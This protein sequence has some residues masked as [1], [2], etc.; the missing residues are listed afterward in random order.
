MIYQRLIDYAL[1]GY[2]QPKGG[3]SEFSDKVRYVE[4]EAANR[5]SKYLSGSPLCFRP[6]RSVTKFVTDCCIN[7]DPDAVQ[8]MVNDPENNM[9]L[10]EKADESILAPVLKRLSF[11]DDICFGE[12]SFDDCLAAFHQLLERFT[13]LNK[14]EFY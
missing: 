8:R 9:F 6:T 14:R 1:W 5:Q 4:K 3:W 12:R 13:V 10:T 7:T 2:F 11:V